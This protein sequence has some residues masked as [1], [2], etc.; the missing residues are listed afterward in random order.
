MTVFHFSGPGHRE[1]RAADGFAVSAQGVDVFDAA[2]GEAT[3]PA[4]YRRGFVWRRR[5]FP[6]N[7]T[8]DRMVFTDP[9]GDDVCVF[10]G[11][12]RVGKGP[13]ARLDIDTTPATPHIQVGGRRVAERDADASSWYRVARDGSTK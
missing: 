5:T 13:K 8:V 10:V 1:Q 2:I 12:R 9:S 4:V 11:E 6:D 7:W 3:E